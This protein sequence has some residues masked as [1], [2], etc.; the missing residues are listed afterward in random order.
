MPKATNEKNKIFATF[1]FAIIA[2]SK[3]NAAK[4]PMI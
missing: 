1:L 3:V 4:K 2:A